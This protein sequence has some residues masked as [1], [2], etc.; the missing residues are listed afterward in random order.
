MDENHDR[1]VSRDDLLFDVEMALRKAERVWPRKRLP[2]DHDRLRPA[3]L[4]VVSH[5]VL[6]G[7]RFF[8]GPPLGAHRTPDPGV[9]PH[10]SGGADDS[11]DGAGAGS[12]RAGPPAES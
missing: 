1:P 10:G 7:L 6:C 4:A 5:L 2:G 11:E 3:A 8:R 9:P 12:V